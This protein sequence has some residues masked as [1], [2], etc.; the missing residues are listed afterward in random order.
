MKSKIILICGDCNSRNY[1]YSNSDK[2]LNL[3]KYCSNCRKT[4]LHYGNR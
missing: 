2:L 3:N 4:T 1:T